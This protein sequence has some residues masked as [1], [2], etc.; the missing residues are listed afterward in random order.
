MRQVAFVMALALLRTAHAG[1][2]QP[3]R[4]S[5]ARCERPLLVVLGESCAVVHV[6]ELS[7]PR[8]FGGGASVGAGVGSATHVVLRSAK[9]SDAL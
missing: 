6:Q 1:F 9:P 7:W 5:T 4:G 8:G 3:L 2:V